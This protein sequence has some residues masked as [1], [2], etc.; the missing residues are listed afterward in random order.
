MHDTVI[1][2]QNSDIWSLGCIYS[3][4][5]RWL[6]DGHRGILTYQQER[7]AETSQIHGFRDG[8][9]FHDG[10]KI[11]PCV[12]KCH[13][14]SVRNLRA[15]DYITRP[16]IDVLVGDM[17]GNAQAR[18]T[19]FRLYQR[20][21]QLVTD[22][23]AD[24]YGARADPEPL[25]TPSF[26]GRPRNRSV[27]VP[28]ANS[29]PPPPPKLPPGYSPMI[30]L[31]AVQPNTEMFTSQYGFPNN[32]SPPHISSP[33]NVASEPEGMDHLPLSPSSLPKPNSPEEMPYQN[34]K[35][36]PEMPAILLDEPEDI[37][38]F[39]NRKHTPRPDSGMTWRPAVPEGAVP[40]TSPVASETQKSPPASNVA[41]YESPSP[42][43]VYPGAAVES[44]PP[45]RS[46]STRYSAAQSE[47][48]PK[49]LVIQGPPKL[50]Y[51]SLEEALEWRRK[52][53]GNGRKIP[54]KDGRYLDRLRDRDHVSDE[55]DIIVLQY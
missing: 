13:R 10:E 15:E 31:H 48:R 38:P 39:T 20:S 54:L 9:C 44:S 50:P 32:A 34:Q 14:S 35:L 1:E 19:A 46:L 25:T 26:H 37:D 41:R 23:K 2:G 7:Q 22:A 43:R 24:L 52:R 47:P 27:T 6:K 17:M 49:P 42:P 3:E 8:D 29:R 55:G 16:V 28:T 21:R 45:Q 12:R 53:K 30:S 11:L 33:V 4:A 5:A 40:S 18:S 51:L 36:P